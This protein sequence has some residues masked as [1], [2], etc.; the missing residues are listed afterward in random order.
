MIVCVDKSSRT[1]AAL[2]ESGTF[3][4]NFLKAGSEDVSSKFASRDD[5]KFAN[6]PWT[7]SSVA[8]GAPK[9]TEHSVA[10]AEC[11]VLDTIEAGDHWIFIGRVEGGEVYGGTPL[12]YFRRTYA[13]WPLETEAPPIR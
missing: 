11:T 9:L 7:P 4:I 13:G 2:Q 6:L 5:D 8:G 12:M 1:L 3:A 10:C